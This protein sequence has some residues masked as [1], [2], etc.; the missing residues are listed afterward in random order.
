MI[1]A[2]ARDIQMPILERFLATCEAFPS[3]PAVATGR[4]TL[5][6]EQLRAAVLT[7]AGSVRAMPG[8]FVGLLLPPTHEFP[9]AYFAALAAGKI[10]LPLNYLLEPHHLD[11]IIEQTK[12][13][14]VI[15]CDELAPLLTGRV[16]ERVRLSAC[17]ESSVLSRAVD[18]PPPDPDRPAVLLYTSGTSGLPKGVLLSARNLLTNADSCRERVAISPEDVTIGV[19]PLFHSFGLTCTLLI[20]L[21][22]GGLVAYLP[23]F[24]PPRLFA[25]IRRHRPSL[26]YAIPSMFRVMVQAD[27]RTDADFSTFRLC[28]SGGEALDPGLAAAFL[29][30]FAVPL[31]EGYGLTETSPVV[32]WNTPDDHRP[33]SVG[34]P[35]PW[36]SVEI[37]SPE[38]GTCAVGED[39][40]IHLRGDSV[41]TEYY[42]AAEA[43]A[44]AF[45][46]GGWFRT[47]DVGH[48]DEDGY[49]W[50]TGRAKDMII[51]SGENVAPREI[52]GT[53][54]SHPDVLEAAV[55]GA[56]DVVRGEVPKAFVVRAPGSAL[57]E[58]AL[59]VFCRQRLARHKCPRAFVF[60]SALPRGRTGKVLKQELI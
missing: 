14:A 48:L 20:P 19:L 26:F 1:N 8:E 13:Q 42:R 16:P 34:K 52:E 58:A 55:I 41:M 50:I 30:Q 38:Q 45:A 36:V 29:E 59:A 4:V 53:L 37:R 31:L 12:L 28:A 49:L 54:T 25:L 24:S 33:G 22:T 21:L 17:L 60:L 32:A 46:P 11:F 27:G 15:T 43:T 51:T 5:S 10:P 23:Q 39:G 40:E 44:S 35:L 56:P 7:A 57:D 47:G 9:I 18:P 2:E 3:R 6:Y